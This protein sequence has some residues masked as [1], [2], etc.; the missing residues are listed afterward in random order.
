MIKKII[1]TLLVVI[2]AFSTAIFA[3]KTASI[4]VH[5]PI[6]PVF[7]SENYN[8]VLKIEVLT[9]Q[10]GV[11]VEGIALQFGIS[12]TDIIEQVQLFY[13]G[14]ENE[15]STDDE[16]KSVSRIEKQTTIP[17]NQIL[18]QGNIDVGLSRSTDGGETWEPM[19]IIMDMGTWG[20]RPVNENGIGD[21]AILTDRNTGTIWVAALW[22]HG[23]PGTHAWFS[24]Q[25]GMDPE[26][27]GQF[28]L[29]KS[30]DDGLTWSDPINITNQIKQP[31]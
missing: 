8:P 3:Q 13:T 2:M 27:T 17:F 11:E 6:Q 10:S 15:F 24:S 14:G 18:L 4:S 20:D 23:Y 12:A 22:I 1:T 26:E 21:P 28:V 25:Q 7:K 5:K 9:T 31:V 19:E 16:A 30:E 29:V